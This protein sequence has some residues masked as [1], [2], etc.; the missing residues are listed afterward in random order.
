MVSVVKSC[1]ASWSKELELAELSKLSRPWTG[2]TP[3]L[4]T[5][6]CNKTSSF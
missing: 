3:L 4:S 2:D 6:S 5:A 1:T